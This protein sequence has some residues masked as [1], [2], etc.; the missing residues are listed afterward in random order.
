MDASGAMMGGACAAP[1][2]NAASVLLAD[3]ESG[4]IP[5]SDSAA[6]GFRA[7]DVARGTIVMPGA[8]ATAD[9]AEFS[10]AT[11][12]SLFFQGSARPQYLDGSATYHPDL[13]N[14]LE[15]YLRIPAGS[16]LL[17]S[18]GTT[19]S[20]YTYHWKPGDAWV[21]SNSSGGNLTDSQMHGY[22]S[23]RFDSAAAE[24]Y[25][26]VVMSTSAFDHS[27]GNY[28]FYAARA[29]VDD[30]T[31]FG[32]LRQFQPVFLASRA[33]GPTSLRF[34]ELRLVTLPPTATMCPAFHGADVP[35]SGGDVLV[36][37]TLS[38]PTDTARTYRVF[39]SSVIGLDRQTL[40]A[41]T[42]DA[43]DVSAVDNLQGAVGSDGGLGAV[44]IFADDGAGKPTGPSLIAAGGE[45]IAVAA[46]DAFRAV[47]VHHVTQA[48][49]GPMQTVMNAGHDYQVRRDTLTTSVI[50]WDPNAP[51]EGDAAV[52]FPGSN[53]DQSH[54]A[55]PGFP[56]YADPPAGW[57][58]SDVPPDQVGGYFVSLLR[59]TP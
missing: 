33:S 18:S 44:E 11:D 48:M 51:A 43:D 31:F 47:L 41:A 35:A 54:P 27:R 38:N 46:H 26:R 9:A 10:F 8:D 4:T 56:P 23:L 55:P 21:G 24:R 25:V 22:G 12:D 40:E 20:I 1:A 34:D 50:V 3:F 57:R 52:V 15:F 29:V 17:A 14:A 37:I 42:H 39:I 53:A 59:L 5:S 13:A 6:E 45:G 32:S 30:L 36:P 19:F 58:S 49:L 28:H 2:S 16:G 7:A